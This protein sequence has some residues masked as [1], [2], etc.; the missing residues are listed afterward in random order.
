MKSTLEGYEIKEEIGSGAFA[1]VYRAEH[2]RTHRPVAI[3]II[4]KIAENGEDMTEVGKRE[5]EVTS[6]MEHP[7]IASVFE[8]REDADAFYVILEYIDNKSLLDFI[9]EMG[10]V[11]TVTA[12]K[13]FGQLVSVIL[14][15]HEHLHVVHRDLKVENILL[16]RFNNIRLIDFG[17]SMD[18]V[19]NSSNMKTLCGSPVYTAPEIIKNIPYSNAVDIWSLGVILYAMICGEF[20]FNN[21]NMRALFHDI[22]HKEPVIPKYLD[23]NLVDLITLMLKK[24]PVERITIESVASHPWVR[25]YLFNLHS[26]FMPPDKEV[27]VHM[28]ALHLSTS[29]LDMVSYAI[30]RKNKMVEEIKAA[31]L[32]VSCK[33]RISGELSLPTLRNPHMNL[34][35][36]IKQSHRS[37]ASTSV[38]STTRPITNHHQERMFNNSGMFPMPRKSTNARQFVNVRRGRTKSGTVMYLP[39][40]PH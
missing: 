28:E 12:Q 6:K 16:D 31:A 17:F 25:D 11:P 2:L 32:E 34:P 23:Y 10:Q 18:Y 35:I 9:N 3:K 24:D 27:I 37:N 26:T 40:F 15:L 7:L 38:E 1:R 20:P 14:Y 30:L 22:T 4:S 36:P 39:A 13:L 19:P 29:P 5:I 21:T 33:T 8:T